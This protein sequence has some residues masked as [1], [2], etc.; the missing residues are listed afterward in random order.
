M[1]KNIILSNYVK[2]IQFYANICK[3]WKQ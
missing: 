3:R 1:T 2:N